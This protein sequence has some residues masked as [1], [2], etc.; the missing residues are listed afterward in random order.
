MRMVSATLSLILL[1]IGFVGI[2]GSL[3]AMFDPIGAKISDDGDPFGITPSPLSSL[4]MLLVYLAIGV[5]GGLLA[6]KSFRKPA[7]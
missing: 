7:H 4:L 2:M 6:R 1:L 5:A 3:F